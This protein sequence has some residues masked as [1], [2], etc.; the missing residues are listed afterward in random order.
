MRY[1][2]ICKRKQRW[3][4]QMQPF[5]NGKRHKGVRSRERDSVHVWVHFTILHFNVQNKTKNKATAMATKRRSTFAEQMH[6]VQFIY[7]YYENSGGCRVDDD[8]DANNNSNN[9]D[10]DSGKAKPYCMKTNFSN[11]NNNNNYNSKPSQPASQPVAAMATIANIITNSFQWC[12]NQSFKG[13][14][15]DG[16]GRFSPLFFSFL[17][18]CFAWFLLSVA[19]AFFL[20]RAISSFRFVRF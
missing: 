19:R 9:N 12:M 11:K 13:S 16:D 3:R 18:W 5:D 14:G 4:K 7:I 15:G 10:C 20:H 17:F 6:R 8:D 1:D 2:T